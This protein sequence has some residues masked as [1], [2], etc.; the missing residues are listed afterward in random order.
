MG[1]EVRPTMSTMQPTAIRSGVR[2][3]VVLPMASRPF[4]A[5][6]PPRN[7]QR[8]PSSGWHTGGKEMPARPTKFS[9]EEAK[10]SAQTACQG[11]FSRTTIIVTILTPVWPR[12]A[13]IQIQMS[14]P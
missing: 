12:T 5:T 8:M 6:R 4:Q 1:A 10:S 7:T 3:R 13:F 11:K 9:M 2:S 14:M